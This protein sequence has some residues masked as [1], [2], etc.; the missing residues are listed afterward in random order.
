M[1]KRLSEKDKETVLEL[2][3]NGE[4]ISEI[5]RATSYAYGTV[6]TIINKSE[7]KEEPETEIETESE[8]NELT[9]EEQAEFWKQ[10]YLE[11]HSELL[12]NGLA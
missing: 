10:K 5:M 2:Y 12:L 9:F 4:S 11:A 8:S 1:G 3:K 7:Q 6:R